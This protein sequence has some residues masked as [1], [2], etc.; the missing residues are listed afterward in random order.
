MR[1]AAA[2]H[3]D[4]GV[5]AAFRECENAVRGIGA[6]PSAATKALLTQLI[7]AGTWG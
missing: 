1:T 6:T 5:L 7:G 2:A 4:D 3:D